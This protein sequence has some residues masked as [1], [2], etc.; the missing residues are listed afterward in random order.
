MDTGRT[1]RYAIPGWIFIFWLVF[2]FWIIGGSA[3]VPSIP[4]ESVTII[5]GFVVA[6]ASSP[7]LGF[8]ISS[9]ANAII[10]FFFGYTVHFKYPD[11]SSERS[12]FFQSLRSQLRAEGLARELDSAVLSL[13]DVAH[14]RLFLQ[15]RNKRAAKGMRSV[16]FLSQTVLRSKSLPILEFADRRSTIYWTQVNSIAALFLG[17]LLALLLRF[18][19][20]HYLG[21]GVWSHPNI[22]HRWWLEG[23]LAVYVAIGV[24]HLLEAR[25]G[26]LEV[27]YNWLMREAWREVRNEST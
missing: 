15:I 24:W 25:L 26:T 19:F 10:H 16:F 3:Y 18:Y 5:L 7:A 12:E 23:P 20:D 17:F 9:L 13:K 22:W 8:V 4:K 27:E 11:D 2:H 14:V 1:Y 21:P 6:L